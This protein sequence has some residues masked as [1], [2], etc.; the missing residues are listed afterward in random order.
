MTVVF[1]GDRA[2]VAERLL[3]RGATVRLLGAWDDAQGEFRVDRFDIDGFSEAH[4]YR[5]VGRST[6]DVADEVDVTGLYHEG[7]E[8]PTEPRRPSHGPVEDRVI[9][10]GGGPWF[11]P[12]QRVVARD[13]GNVGTVVSVDDLP[14]RVRV[15][16]VARTGS[17]TVV[18]FTS[19]QLDPAAVA[20][21]T[22]AVHRA[23]PATAD[24]Q[25]HDHREPTTTATGSGPDPEG[26]AAVVE[27]TGVSAAEDRVARAEVPVVGRAARRSEAPRVGGAGRSEPPV[28]VL[29][30]HTRRPEPTGELL[31]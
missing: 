16:F 23:S 24:R 20:P 21:T 1:R 18:A 4:K 25:Q 6:V 28:G 22:E 10:K 12:G 29:R 3:V 14:D 8:A 30:V 26:P 31:L 7:N 2:E 19:D 5:L 17:E 27:P 9:S 11:V 13:R 15:R